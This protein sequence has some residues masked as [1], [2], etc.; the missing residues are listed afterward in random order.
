M[1]NIMLCKYGFGNVL[2]FDHQSLHFSLTVFLALRSKFVALKSVECGAL[3]NRLS[4][5]L[6]NC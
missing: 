5:S 2:T 3:V 6:L 4:L 1:L